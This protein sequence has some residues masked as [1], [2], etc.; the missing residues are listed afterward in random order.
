MVS[1]PKIELATVEIVELE[2]RFVFREACGQVVDDQV[3]R[4][5]ET[6]VESAQSH[7]TIVLGRSARLFDPQTAQSRG[8]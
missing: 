8:H 4:D 1:L 5:G 2:L 3:G 7:S 6:I